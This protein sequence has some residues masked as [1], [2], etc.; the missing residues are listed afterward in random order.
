MVKG[1][2]DDINSLHAAFKGA[3]VIFGVTDYWGPFLDPANLAKLKPG[4]TLNEFC[5][6]L[7]VRR[8]RNI[9]LAAAGVD[10]LERFV[11]SSLSD[12]R[13]WSKGKYTGVYHFQSK[14]NVVEYIAKELPELKK[15]SS[16]IQVGYYMTNWRMPSFQPRKVSESP[17]ASR[18][19]ILG[20]GLTS[21][22]ILLH[23]CRIETKLTV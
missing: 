6:E 4:Q 3:D 22:E 15:K 2:L 9:A 14:A 19:S 8:G 7:E 20:A 21:Q 16:F 11:F 1:E 18:H 17:A 5:Y 23:I 13:K 10:A 12:A